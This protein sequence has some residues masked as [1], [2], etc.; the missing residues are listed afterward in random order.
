[1]LKWETIASFL[2]YLIVLKIL[3][4]ILFH[5]LIAYKIYHGGV[6]GWLSQ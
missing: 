6:H 4:P 2:L 5:I 1:M 3:S